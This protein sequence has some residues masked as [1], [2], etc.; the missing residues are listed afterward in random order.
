[1]AYRRQDDRQGRKKRLN[2]KVW[3]T[4]WCFLVAKFFLECTYVE[5]GSR[6]IGGPNGAAARRAAKT[7]RIG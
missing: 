2:K 1:M 5:D 6:H 3:K 4:S 7:V